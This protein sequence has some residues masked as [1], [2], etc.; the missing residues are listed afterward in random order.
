MVHILWKLLWLLRETMTWHTITFGS[1][2]RCWQV[3]CFWTC[4][5]E[6]EY[7]IHAETLVMQYASEACI[8]KCLCAWFFHSTNNG[9]WSQYFR[10]SIPV[11]LVLVNQLRKV[12]RVA[13]SVVIMSMVNLFMIWTST[14]FCMLLL[15]GC[16]FVPR[17]N[18]NKFIRNHKVCVSIGAIM[19]LRL[20]I[21]TGGQWHEDYDIFIS[22]IGF[23]CRTQ[24]W[25]PFWDFMFLLLPYLGTLFEHV[26]G[27]KQLPS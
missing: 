11:I 26:L 19:I 25:T 12:T 17:S 20:D 8:I 4:C 14:V 5:I 10:S 23:Y 16:F 6:A 24:Y 27:I 15:C 1:R 3:N 7:S 13:E 2:Y 18:Y 22:Y 21:K 9:L